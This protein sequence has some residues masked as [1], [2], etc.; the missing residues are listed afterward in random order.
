MKLTTSIALL[1]ALF[2][3]SALCADK[4]AAFFDDGKVQ[5]IRLYFDDANW[6]NT[7]YKAHSNDAT[8]PYFPARFKYGDTVRDSIG[9]RFKGNASFSVSSVKKSFKLDFNE[10]QS[11]ATFLGLKKLNLNNLHLEPDFLREKMFLQRRRPYC[12]VPPST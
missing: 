7:L 4:A 3:G 10:Y 12:Q 6:Y 8:D 11:D 5:E 2:T 1:L 9:V